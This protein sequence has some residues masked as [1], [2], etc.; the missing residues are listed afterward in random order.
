MLTLP[1][2]AALRRSLPGARMWYAG[3]SEFGAL[4]RGAR[5]AD[6]VISE[7]RPEM[8][9]LFS[10]SPDA[11]DGIR[12]ALGRIDLAVSFITS[13]RLLHNIL[14]AGAGEVLSCSALPPPDGTIH[15]ADHLLSVLRGRFDA[16]AR[17]LPRCA[18]PARV[19]ERGEELLR[20]HGLEPSR[21][22][23]L[24]PGSGSPL[25]DW[26]V[27]RFAELAK[28]V[29][30]RLGLGIAVL[31]GPAEVDRAEQFRG[32]LGPLADAWFDSPPVKLL[33]G[34]LAG[35]AAYVGNDSGV[36]HLAA[37]AGAPTV[38]VFGPTDPGV[39]GPRGGNVTT[40]RDA[41]GELARVGVDRVFDALR[42]V[43][44]DARVHP[45]P[46]SGVP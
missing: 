23:A 3:R 5:L 41:S 34:V 37:A 4:A 22:L 32:A 11:P 35:S 29:R 9:A 16:P 26:P 2:L 6:E 45:A 25:K 33:A 40:V 24:H 21:S 46:P 30:E 7:D 36:T 31:A 13:Q 15:A 18:V 27:E 14:A 19:R 10:D 43:L 12:R 1:V 42:E 28:L 44:G 39:W 8:V 38:G 20:K 17:A